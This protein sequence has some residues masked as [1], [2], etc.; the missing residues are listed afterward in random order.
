[1]PTRDPRQRVHALGDRYIASRPIPS[2]GPG[3]ASAFLPATFASAAGV[4][5][6]RPAD[7]ATGTRPGT[8]HRRGYPTRNILTE[9]IQQRCGPAT[10]GSTEK[11]S[12]L[13]KCNYRA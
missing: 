12:V 1:M 10:P 6:P 8:Q 7:R 11:G 4:G 2:A 5:L 3:R 9:S 13:D